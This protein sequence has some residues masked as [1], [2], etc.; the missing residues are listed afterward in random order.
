MAKTKLNQDPTGM[1]EHMAEIW[2]EHHDPQ[3]RAQKEL[4]KRREEKKKIKAKDLG[5]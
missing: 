4:E 1:T 5:I 3:K 2:K